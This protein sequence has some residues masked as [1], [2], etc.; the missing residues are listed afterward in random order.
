M[1]PQ[2]SSADTWQQLVDDESAVLIDVRTET[3][4]KT[5][6]VPDLSSI[7]KEARFVPWN[8]EQGVK[9]AYFT[10]V[11]TDGLGPDTPIYLLCRSGARSNA[12]AERLA[13]AG[14]TQAHNIIAGFEGPPGPDGRH[15]GGWKDSLPHSDFRHD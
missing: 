10:D 3:E 8:D 1:I 6:G 7:G 14:F 2:I 13:A 11:A 4:W 5:I 15:S 12:A 9:N